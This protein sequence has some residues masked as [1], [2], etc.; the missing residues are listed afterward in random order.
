VSPRA[1]RPAFPEEGRGENEGARA[2]V[3]TPHPA[4][5]PAICSEAALPADQAAFAAALAAGTFYRVAACTYARESAALIRQAFTL[6]N[7]DGTSLVIKSAKDADCGSSEASQP[8]SDGA[9]SVQTSAA[10]QPISGPFE[11]AGGSG[12]NPSVCTYVGCASGKCDAKNVRLTGYTGDIPAAAPLPCGNATL[13]LAPA[14]A[15]NVLLI[16][17]SISMTPPYTPGG[18]GGALEKLLAARGIT[19]QHAG[20]DFSGGQDADTRTG[21][22]CTNSSAPSWLSFAGTF[23]VI[24]FNFGLHDLANYGPTLPQLP[25][26]DYERNLAAI[27]ARLAARAKRVVWT[28][29]TPAPDVPQPYNRSYALV[30]E[31]NA[32]AL[33][34]LTAAA[35]PGKLLVDDLWSAF[36]A[37]CGAH[38]T[39][40]PLQLPKN[41][42][43]TPEGIAFAAAEAE[44]VILAALGGLAA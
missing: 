41:V 14:P 1:A 28:S 36:I 32:A 15:R 21:L 22:R 2:L 35:A 29:T 24:H 27:Y 8:V 20:G 11:S 39:A 16:G 17:D 6:S 9:I 43:L 38:Y 10:S 26:P 42:H 44:K 40:C 23:D 33:R 37:R 25:L 13:P 3:I 7:P 4:P 30:E 19:A 31:Y 34:A 5:L 18:Y 12:V